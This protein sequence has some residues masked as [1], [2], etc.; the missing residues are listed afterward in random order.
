M[1]DES[2]VILAE[3]LQEFTLQFSTK[4]QPSLAETKSMIKG[5]ELAVTPQPE[6]LEAESD[7]QELIF[8][9]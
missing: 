1:N 7:C 9:L 6:I 2:V 5:L 8:V 4:M 3:L